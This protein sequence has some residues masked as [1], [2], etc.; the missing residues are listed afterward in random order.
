MQSKAAPNITPG[1]EVLVQEVMA[2]IT[3]DPCFNSNDYPLYSNL[4]VLATYSGLIPK[5]LKPFSAVKHLVKS[6]FSYLRGTKSWGL[7]GPATLGSTV[8]RSSSRILENV[9]SGSFS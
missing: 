5:P 6:A 8:E 9:K 4:T 1:L 2:A 7:F 3:T